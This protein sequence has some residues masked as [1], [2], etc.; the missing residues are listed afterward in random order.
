MIGGSTENC[1]FPESH[2]WKTGTR[3]PEEPG[4]GLYQSFLVLFRH[5]LVTLLHTCKSNFYSS[6]LMIQREREREREKGI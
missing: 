3:V 5:L 1:A 6:N 4:H 2:G